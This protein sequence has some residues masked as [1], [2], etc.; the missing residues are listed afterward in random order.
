[1]F[2]EDFKIIKRFILLLSSRNA[3]LLIVAFGGILCFLP[4]LLGMESN[5]ENSSVA[6]ALSSTEAKLSGVVSL[7]LCLPLIV[8]LFIDNVQNFFL[9]S[10]SKNRYFRNDKNLG[11]DVIDRFEVTL[12]IIANLIS[13]TVMFLPDKTKNIALIFCCARRCYFLL[14]CGSVTCS[15]NRYSNRDFPAL[16]ISFLLVICV[17]GSVAGVF[18]NNLDPNGKG[19]M[20]NYYSRINYIFTY[21]VFCSIVI[22]SCRWLVRF[23]VWG[24]SFSQSLDMSV[25]RLLKKLSSN[26]NGADNT[27]LDNSSN[28]LFVNDPHLPFKI[29]YTASFVVM[30]IIVAGLSTRFKVVSGMNKEQLFLSSL[31]GAFLL[32]VISAINRQNTRQSEIW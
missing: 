22:L 23:T 20:N 8:D 1:M 26:V 32:L 28:D 5:L 14:I 24:R 2:C 30:I 3:H 13:Y 16:L 17:V 27:A 11:I 6:N 9:R 10:V 15:F 31:P 18:A 25:F 4:V 21:S 7:T 29:A 12:V 19:V